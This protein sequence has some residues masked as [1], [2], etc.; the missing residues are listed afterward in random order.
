MSPWMPAP[1]PES[2]PAIVSATGLFDT[3]AVYARLLVSFAPGRTSRHGGW[4]AD[5]GEGLGRFTRSGI[6]APGA[7]GEVDFSFRLR[8]EE[9]C[10]G[11]LLSEGRHAGMHEGSVQ[12]A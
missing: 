12:P 9:R 4:N 1:P 2:E 5:S 10:P 11:L 7:V 6:H 3:G 8:R